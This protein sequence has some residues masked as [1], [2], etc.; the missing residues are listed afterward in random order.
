MLKLLQSQGFWSTVVYITTFFLLWREIYKGTS[1]FM[2]LPLWWEYGKPQENIML[3]LGHV[4]CSLIT[5]IVIAWVLRL[6]I[7]KSMVN[8]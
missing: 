6:T 8:P 3:I 5:G 7:K 2:V 1:V 4:S